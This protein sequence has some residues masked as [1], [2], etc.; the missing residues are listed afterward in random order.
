MNPGPRVPPAG[1]VEQ[2]MCSLNRLERALWGPLIRNGL[3]RPE[4]RLVTSIPR[5]G[6]TAATQLQ[7]AVL[8]LLPATLWVFGFVVYLLA[9]A[10]YD[11]I[12]LAF[13][14]AGALCIVFGVTR[15]LTYRFHVH[16]AT[17]AR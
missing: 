8:W 3:T 16:A 4:T 12:G 10:P 15:L 5:Y 7:V 2:A 1:E 14:G 17:G 13:V 11:Y 6:V 9:S